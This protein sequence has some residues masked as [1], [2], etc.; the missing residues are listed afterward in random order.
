VAP[1]FST[2]TPT[3]PSPSLSFTSSHSLLNLD[4]SS[5]SL[6]FQITFD[7]YP[8]SQEEPRS[9]LHAGI[10]ADS[11]DRSL[12]NLRTPNNRIRTSS[13]NRNTVAGQLLTTLNHFNCS[14]AIHCRH[15]TTCVTHALPWCWPPPLSLELRLVQSNTHMPTSTRRRMPR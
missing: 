1:L 10:S 11:H 13:I 14:C 3:Q 9:L 15:K 4:A 7:P 2:F 6:I 12:L 5:S 8:Y